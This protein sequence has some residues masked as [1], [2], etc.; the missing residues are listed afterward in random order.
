MAEKGDM[1][2]P[3]RAWLR[4]QIGI[5]IGSRGSMDHFYPL[6]G[7][8]EAG[9]QYGVHLSRSIAELIGICSRRKR[10]AVVG[11]LCKGPGHR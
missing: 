8:I 1:I 9:A 2:S 3:G 5:D 11:M 4:L 10:G 6:A 7:V